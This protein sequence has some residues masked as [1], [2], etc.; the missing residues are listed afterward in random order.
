MKNSLVGRIIAGFL[1]MLL[2]VLGLAVFSF[3]STY[4]I[5]K[6]LDA[7]VAKVSALLVE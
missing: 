7:D 5:A 1:V 4:R 6:S 3:V 2:L